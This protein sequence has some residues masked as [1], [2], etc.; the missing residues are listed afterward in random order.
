MI[1]DIVIIDLKPFGGEGVI[2]LSKPTFRRAQQMKN[3]LGRSMGASVNAKG[4]GTM[5]EALLGDIE[6]IKMLAYVKSAPFSANI[7]SFFDFCDILDEKRNGS[8]SELFALI[9]EKVVELEE[10]PG[11][12]ES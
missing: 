4:Q 7:N 11:P 10:S 8:A 2:E 9:Q 6:V 5:K 12:L 3:E 1:N